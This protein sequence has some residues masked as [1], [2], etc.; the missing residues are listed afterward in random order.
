MPP[1]I[2]VIIPNHNGEKTIGLCLEA[3]FSSHHN[4]F[5]VIVVDDCSTDNSVN[6]I[7]KFPCKLCRLTEHGGASKTR[8]VGAR[9][10]SGEALFFID[11]DC[12]LLPYTLEKASLAYQANGP[13]VA[14]GGTYTK[15]PFDKTFFSI[16]L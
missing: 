14:V 1:L 9:E 16:F 3:A 6:I 8:N 2:S 11:A 4:N 12:L 7:K 10:S 15:L 5:E 13:K